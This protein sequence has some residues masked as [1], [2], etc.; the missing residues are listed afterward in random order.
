M[1][2][3]ELI[4]TINPSTISVEQL[5]NFK[6]A[7]MT[8][9]RINASHSDIEEI[10]SLVSMIR[11]SIDRE[12]IKIMLDL[13]GPEYRLT[14]Y[15]KTLRIKANDEL[16]LVPKE[17]VPTDE[18][19]ALQTDY[20]V[21][22]MPNMT[23]R[24]V[25]FMNGE[26]RS[27]ITSAGID[28]IK[29][30]FLN[31]GALR[32]NAHIKINDVHHEIPY[33]S[34]YDRSLID[35]AVSERIE[36]L[37]ISMVRA[38][39]DVRDVIALLN[40]S[41]QKPTLVVKFETLESIQDP[42]SIISLGDAFFVA[43]GDLGND[44][45]PV[46]IPM[47]QKE[48]VS[49]CNSYAKPVYIA[50]QMMSSMQRSPYPTR[51]EISDVANAVYEGC[52][53]ITLSEE[54]AV[55]DYPLEAVRLAR[56]IIDYTGSYSFSVQALEPIFE[57]VMNTVSLKPIISHIQD[58]AERIWHN[59]WAEANAGNISWNVTAQITSL[60]ELFE[61]LSEYQHFYIVSKTCSRYRDIA[62]DPLSNLILVA[63]NEDSTAYYP[64]NRV[65]TSEWISH[66]SIHQ[67]LRAAGRDET[68]ILHAH[69]TSIVVLSQL[70]EYDHGVDLSQFLP[71]LK[72]YLPGGIGFTS[73][74]EPGSVEL[75]RKS[76]ESL[77]NRKTIIWQKHGILC[78]GK[79]IDEAFDYLEI[80]NKA[81]D[82]FLNLKKL[83]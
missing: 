69:P 40:Q 11:S 24:T 32:T 78:F 7:G 54:T 39:S 51:A 15:D 73:Y 12:S 61:E 46:S 55:G 26:L 30:Q 13:P 58:V 41:S 80:V 53:G 5:V 14:G 45:N 63:V 19:Q 1:K 34:A 18:I 72:I 36:M 77:P 82:V 4:C 68:V 35:Y 83:I 42:E 74:S 2:P 33:I 57:Q 20:P 37:A 25:L 64:P 43:R 28:Q 65:P 27:I 9:A 10:S 22:G 38:A 49:L 75:S 48:L 21:F 67:Y 23:G 52:D 56:E 70:P 60:L 79:D 66:L 47:L 17:F 76:I 81:A 31:S 6:A 50:T 59:G 16:I 71:E 29:I 44:V 62:R 3:I 8:I